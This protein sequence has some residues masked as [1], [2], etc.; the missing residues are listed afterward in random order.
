MKLRIVQPFNRIK[1]RARQDPD[2][3]CRVHKNNHRVLLKV[4]ATGGRHIELRR[5]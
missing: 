2:V 3:L 1:R 5:I 4:I